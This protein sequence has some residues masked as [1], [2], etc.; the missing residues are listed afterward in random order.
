MAQ[1]YGIRKVLCK[2]TIFLNHQSY[3]LITVDPDQINTIIN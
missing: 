2:N 3:V 1:K